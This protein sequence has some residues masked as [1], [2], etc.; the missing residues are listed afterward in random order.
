MARDKKLAERYILQIFWFAVDLY[1]NF[2]R[3][4]P[5]FI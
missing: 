2:G 1:M 5:K 4:R 3:Q